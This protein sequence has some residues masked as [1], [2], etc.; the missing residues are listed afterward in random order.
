MATPWSTSGRACSNTGWRLGGPGGDL[1]DRAPVVVA[2]LV[3]ARQ[4]PATA[5]GT[6]FLLLEDEHG[7]INV[8]VPPPVYQQYREAIHHSPFL[9]VQ[10]R[11]ERDERVL[12]VV[13]SRFRELNARRADRSAARAS[14]AGASSTR[15]SSAGLP[16]ARA[17]RAGE[18]VGGAAIGPGMP[19]Q[20]RSG[21][22]MRRSGSP[23]V[24]E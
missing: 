19:H 23:P 11:L 18:A 16:A 3:V 21:P 10:G 1:A 9:L 6:V 20:P 17:P 2:G 24:Q 15:V 22:A 4:H 14:S 5:R 12:N 8:I 7:F 13:A